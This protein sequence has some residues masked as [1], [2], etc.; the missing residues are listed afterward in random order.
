MLVFPAA[1]AAGRDELVPS[2]LP[3]DGR[4]YALSVSP[5]GTALA[6]LSDPLTVDGRPVADRG[7]CRNDA[8]QAG[9]WTVRRVPM[10]RG[11]A[12][13]RPHPGFQPGV[14]DGRRNT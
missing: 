6:G 14:M 9:N 7:W 5:A 1:C 2:S 4:R 3:A 11:G 12:E 13:R 8:R 10:D